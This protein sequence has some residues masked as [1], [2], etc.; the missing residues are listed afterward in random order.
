MRCFQLFL[1]VGILLGACTLCAQESRSHSLAL[2]WGV[3]M[4][5]G[6][7]FL[8]R[9]ACIAPAAEWD[10]RISKTFSVGAGIGYTRGDESGVTSDFY[11]GD[12][13]TGFTDR[14]LILLPLTAHLRWF[15]GAS[16]QQKLQPFIGVAAGGQYAEFRITGDQINTSRGRSWGG[17]VM[18]EAGISFAPVSGGRLR[19]EAACA[20]QY[21]S[22]RWPVMH[23][24]SLRGLYVRAGIRYVFR[25]QQRVY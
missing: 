14:R 5:S 18:P 12:L 11:D 1:C 22:N 19:F 4:P 20:W 8:A 21:A 10:W 2:H 23:V 15:P 17:V 9:A 16:P 7:S 24:G 6:G 25:R 13:V 3:W